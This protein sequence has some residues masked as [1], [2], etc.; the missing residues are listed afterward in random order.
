LRSKSLRSGR[1]LRVG[2]HGG[3]DFRDGVRA[4]G[5]GGSLHRGTLG[6][7]RR[8]VV[9]VESAVSRMT[10]PLP[11][12]KVFIVAILRESARQLHPVGPGGILSGVDGVVACPQGGGSSRFGDRRLPWVSC[13][14]P[15]HLSSH[16]GVLDIPGG[17][18]REGLL[19][20]LPLAYGESRWRIVTDL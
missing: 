6:T 14:A 5:F 18:F 13:W 4:G 10:T 19:K 17:A 2:C 1:G 11:V 8:S 9:L 16:L 15:F 3:E 20:A 7:G 12:A